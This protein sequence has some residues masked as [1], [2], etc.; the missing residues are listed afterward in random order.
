MTTRLAATLCFL[1]MQ[2]SCII[3]GS[4]QTK[5]YGDAIY[6]RIRPVWAKLATERADALSFGTAIV[7][8]EISADG[9]PEHLKVTSNTGNRALAELALATIRQTRFPPIPSAVLG[10]LPNKRFTAD[11]EFVAVQ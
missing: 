9:R 3:A 10:T 6:A 8:F 11:F 5:A 7:H 4:S 2:L 1:L